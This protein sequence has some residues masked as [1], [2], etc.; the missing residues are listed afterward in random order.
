MPLIT[1]YA[2]LNFY[3]YDLMTLLPRRDINK[4]N[5]DEEKMLN[6]YACNLSESI[7]QSIEKVIKAKE[8]TMHLSISNLTNSIIVVSCVYILTRRAPD[9]LCDYNY[10]IEF[11]MTE[12]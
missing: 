8:I 4:I 11:K 6:K 10:I 3:F 7:P 1:C 12:L 2:K 5:F 9:C